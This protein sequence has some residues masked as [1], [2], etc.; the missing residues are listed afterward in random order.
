MSSI[1]PYLPYKDVPE[2]DLTRV[3]GAVASDDKR[4]VV[5]SVGGDDGILTFLIQSAFKH[6]AKYIREN[7]LNFP[8]PDNYKRIVAY[9]QS[10]AAV[11]HGDSADSRPNRNAANKSAARPAKGRKSKTPPASSEPANGG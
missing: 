4:T 7:G 5:A 6:T 10:G 8:D 2:P 1:R 11:G 3:C 9:V